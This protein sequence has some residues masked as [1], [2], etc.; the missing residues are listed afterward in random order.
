MEESKTNKLCFSGFNSKIIQIKYTPK[1]I[2]FSSVCLSLSVT[3]PPLPQHI[4][5][6]H[7]EYLYH[8]DLMLPE[9]EAH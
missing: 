8:I 1:G 2:T 3:A 9:T 4:Y 7:L 5:C 6:I